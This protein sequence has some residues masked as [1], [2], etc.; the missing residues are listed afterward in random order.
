MHWIFE[1]DQL[2]DV[3]IPLNFYIMANRGLNRLHETTVG[4]L[5]RGI[6]VGEAF[7][8][9]SKEDISVYVF[10]IC[11]V[12]GKNSYATKAKEV[13]KCYN[14]YRDYSKL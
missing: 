14:H 6:K 2:G 7:C 11:M 9:V 5:G 3:L 4:T 1:D 10:D 8:T 12:I 13:N